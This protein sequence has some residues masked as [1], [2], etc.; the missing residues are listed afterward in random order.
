MKITPLKRVDIKQT[1]Q[2]LKKIINRTFYYS[3]LA[4]KKELEKF[5]PAIIRKE[6]KDKNNLF[7]VAKNKEKIIGV[8]N[9]YYEAGM[10][11]ADWL[12][13][14]SK[15][16]RSEVAESLM[17]YLEEKFKKEKVH[18]IWCDCRTVNKES[19]A[20]LKKLKFKKIVKIDKHW[21]KQDFYLWQKYL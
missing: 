2:L 6:F 4:R 19:I 10:F 15:F 13:V 16:R 5:N 1:S 12:V 9:G 3:K 20:L 7:L 14:D 8:L 17:D 21:Y 11:W 18:K